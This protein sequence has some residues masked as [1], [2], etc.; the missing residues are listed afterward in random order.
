[1]TGVGSGASKKFD[2]NEFDIKHILM[3]LERERPKHAR[4]RPSGNEKSATLTPK[5]PKYIAVRE[6]ILSLALLSP[7]AV[8]VPA[9]ALFCAG[10]LML[11]WNKQPKAVA[12]FTSAAVLI[13]VLLFAGFFVQHRRKHVIRNLYLGRP[14]L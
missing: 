1:M 9:F 6:R 7:I 4:S 2:P 3:L 8:A 10:I 12:I 14:S 13:C 5:L 11:A